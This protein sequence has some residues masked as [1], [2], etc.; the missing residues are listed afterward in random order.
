MSNEF[1]SWEEMSELEQAQCTYW[2][3]Y[4]DAYGV[5]PRGVD[6]SSWTLEQFEAEFASLATA[7]EQEDA[8]R[9]TA[10]AEAITKFEQHVTNIICMGARNR[11]TALKW[12]MDA[13]NAN[14]DWEYFCFT[15]GLPY[16]YFRKAA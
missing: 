11:E 3:M 13:S 9:K 5:R 4:K 14:G 6:T 16:N 12:I 7:I 10:E 2:D 8:Q 1:K 15:Q